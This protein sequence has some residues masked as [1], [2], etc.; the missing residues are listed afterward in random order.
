MLI[1]NKPASLTPI[2]PESTYALASPE[3][4]KLLLPSLNTK[5]RTKLWIHH[6]HQGSTPGLFHDQAPSH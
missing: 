5:S 4:Q 1:Q 6:Q 2:K 3:S